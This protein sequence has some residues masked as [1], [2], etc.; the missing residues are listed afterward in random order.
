M[1]TLRNIFA[2]I[3]LLSAASCA[4]DN[5][6]APSY[7]VNS[8]D[9]VTVLGRM[10]R[11]DD[12]D[13]TTRGVK[14]E[15]EAKLTS[16]AVA[17]FPVK[18]DGTALAGPCAYWQYTDNQAE[19]LFEINRTVNSFNR[20]AR[21]AMY[22]FCNMPELEDFGIGSTLD[23][24][25]TTAQEVK[26]ID[27]PTNGFPMIG[28][29]G[30]TFSTALD[31]D[32]QLF[33]LSPTKNNQANGELVAP[34]VAKPKA[35]GSGWGDPQTQTL[36]TIPMKA[37]F[38]KVNFSIEVRPDQ[39]I[40]GNYSPQFTLDGYTVNNVPSKVDFNSASNSDTEVLSDGYSLN[41]AD[42]TTAVGANKIN[43]S[44]YLPERLLTPAT[45][46][47]EYD[48]PFGKG[49]DIRDEDL[50][51]RQRYKSMLL[52][53]QQKATNI[54]ISGRF[55]DHQNHSWDVDYT[56]YLGADNYGDFN[57]L[58]N[59][60]YNNYVTI[61]G[62]QSSSDMSDKEGA[63]SIDHRVNVT[64]TQPAIISLRREVLLDS[65]FEVR[66]LRVRKSEIGD[67]EGINAVKVEVLNPGSA[68]TKTGT[69]WMRL[70]RSFGDG[71]LAGSPEATVNGQPTTIY[72]DSDPNS[73]SYG[74]RKFFTYNLIDGVDANATDATLK[75]STEVILPLTD[76]TECCWIYI[77]ECTETGDGIRAGQIKVT[78]GSLSGSTFTPANNASYPDVT[79]IINQR[80][81][82]DVTGPSG[83][84]YHIEYEEEYLHNFDADDNY[85]ETEY[86]GMEW[87]LDGLQLSYADNSDGDGHFSVIAKSG[88]SWI[89]D[90]IDGFM[91]Y[92]ISSLNSFYDFYVKKHDS[93]VM[94][95][96]SNLHDRK[97]WDFCNEI[98]QV[99]NGY[100]YNVPAAKPE[101]TI[102]VLAL[103]EKP[104][105][106]IEYCY[107]KNKRNANGQVA[108]TGNT[109]NLNWYLPAIDEIEDI[110]MSKYG[111]G[112]YTYSRF[113]D[114]QGQYYWSS[115][116]AFNKNL[117]HYNAAVIWRISAEYD[118]YIDDVL[119]ARATRV[120]YDSS[121][122]E[123]SSSVTGIYEVIHLRGTGSNDKTPYNLEELLKTQNS[124]S[125]NYTYNG[126]FL[127]METIRDTRTFTK[128]DLISRKPGNQ[129]R[130]EKNRVR[131]VR[132]VATQQ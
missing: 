3:A 91:N 32:N 94:S 108:W 110:V 75:N 132:K 40:E 5:V 62:I 130:N 2:I 55:R 57:I 122:H 12:K 37:M 95:I 81:L 112:L 26:G 113:I 93:G 4:V 6:D 74:K 88:D 128:S 111:G 123:E 31:R 72:I 13:V 14:D 63:I 9:V 101:N 83:R 117:L 25:L 38:A 86:D 45:T 46:W 76:D 24:M 59:S 64:R 36:L 78:Y 115:Q 49:S 67:V 100:G 20:N 34:T 125:Y 97:G 27:I 19:L 69:W 82:F 119:R 96:E 124:I 11:F 10:T 109:A 90:I 71:T 44:F 77:D 17:I 61:R 52:S 98:I 7:G 22:V 127:G 28:S 23:D 105:S 56:I 116:P 43:F 48:Y 30:D 65:H 51:Y 73:P 121:F 80:K 92:F 50:V 39:T 21:Y 18:E 106:A 68:D 33:I 66:P 107:N 99:A 29:L 118:Y 126:G 8:S 120:V 87:G 47:D 79:Y 1:R 53:E 131:C 15:N 104:K 41:N 58:R 103:N 89:N 35:D 129:L 114:F 16:M 60:E 102:D 84:D 42:R 70:E 54:V 85:G